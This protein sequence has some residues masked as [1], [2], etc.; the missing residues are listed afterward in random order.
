MSIVYI[1]V[2]ELVRIYQSI[3]FNKKCL[4]SLNG[5]LIQPV[6]SILQLF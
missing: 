3:E 1:F 6:H 2:F 5:T 4:V